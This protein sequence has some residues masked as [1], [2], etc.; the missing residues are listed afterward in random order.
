MLTPPESTKEMN[1]SVSLPAYT[2]ERSMEVGVG[3][4][5]GIEEGYHVMKTVTECHMPEYLKEQ[6]KDTNTCCML[7]AS[8]RRCKDMVG[9]K[10]GKGTGIW[11]TVDVA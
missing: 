9:R 11:H 1:G 3:M 10:N 5:E 4:R 6:F 7:C 2:F 8:C